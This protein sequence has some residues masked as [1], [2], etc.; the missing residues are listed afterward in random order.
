MRSETFGEETNLLLENETQYCGHPDRRPAAVLFTT[1]RI[2]IKRAVD[3]TSLTHLASK[4]IQSVRSSETKLRK[5]VCAVGTVTE[6][7][8]VPWAL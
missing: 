1:F 6:K 4:H 2:R 5:I 8:Y 3:I 7:L